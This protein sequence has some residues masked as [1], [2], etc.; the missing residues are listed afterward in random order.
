M[1]TN[2]VLDDELV[3]EAFKY[4]PATTK[5]ALVDHALR[6]FV[7]NH[8]RGDLRELVGKVNFRKDYDYKSLR[9]GRT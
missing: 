2:V 3:T 9:K 4:S 5:R 7:Q 6:E 1:R 8:S